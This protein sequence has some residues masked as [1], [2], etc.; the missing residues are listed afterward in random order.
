MIIWKT[1]DK[2]LDDYKVLTP[3]V[4]AARQLVEAGYKVGKGDIVGY[5][6]VKGGGAKLAYRVKPYML[7]KDNREIDIDYYVEKQIVP[8]AMRIL[9]VLGVKESQL[10]MGKTGKSILDYFS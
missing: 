5:V 3:H 1:L 9:E 7:V 8:A 10:M 4:A 6:I 2:S